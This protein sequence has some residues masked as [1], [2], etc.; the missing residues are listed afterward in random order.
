MTSLMSQRDK[1]VFRKLLRSEPKA[2]Y[3]SCIRIYQKY[4]SLE[5][6]DKLQPDNNPQCNKKEYYP[7]LQYK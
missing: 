2:N 3:F 7:I 4:F 6:F 1:R 5:Y